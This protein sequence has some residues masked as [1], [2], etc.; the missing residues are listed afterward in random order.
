MLADDST[1]RQPFKEVF[2]VLFFP[3]IFLWIIVF[4]FVDK[5]FL[6]GRFEKRY[7]Q[8]LQAQ[9]AKDIQ[10]RIPSLFADFGGRIIPN[11]EDYSPAFDYAAV[12]I[13]FDGMLLRFIRGRMDF[14]VDVAPPDKPTAWREI[15]SIVKN[16]DLP[17]NPNPKV[18]Y[19][20]LND[21]GRFFQVNVDIIR[22]EVSK[23]DWRPAAGWLVPIA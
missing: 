3:V 20:G 8:K 1:R 11:T 15:S 10:E 4:D 5:Y 14:R 9:F 23:P 6:D 13:S 22:H 12:T 21:F 19:Y 17:G 16:S 18:D 7:S 2:T